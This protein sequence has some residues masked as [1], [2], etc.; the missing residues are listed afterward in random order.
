MKKFSGNYYVRE[1]EDG[2]Y[3]IIKGSPDDIELIPL[4]FTVEDEMIGSDI[5]EEDTE[6]FADYLEK[7]LIE[8]YPDSDVV[9]S[10]SPYGPHWPNVC[11]EIDDIWESAMQ[12]ALQ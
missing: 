5:S 7:K 1:N 3:S 2:T 9:V 8:R 4:H 11:R 6:K 12:E 10:V